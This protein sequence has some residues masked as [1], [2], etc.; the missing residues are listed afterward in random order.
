MRSSPTSDYLHHLHPR[1]ALAIEGAV[2]H[3]RSSLPPV[4]RARQITS[5]ASGAVADLLRSL[6]SQ[7]EIMRLLHRLRR[8]AR[9]VRELHTSD[10]RLNR[11]ESIAFLLRFHGMLDHAFFDLLV[12]LR[13]KHEAEIERVRSEVLQS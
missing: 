5:R 13:R 2:P 7:G 1:S 6:F 4:L 12:E 3:G 9:I 10:P 11:W 8:G